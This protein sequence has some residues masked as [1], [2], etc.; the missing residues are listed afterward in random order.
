METSFRK[1]E[2]STTIIGPYF[3]MMVQSIPL[4][5]IGKPR[6]VKDHKAE[7]IAE[8][9]LPLLNV[10]RPMVNQDKNPYEPQQVQLWISSA[11]EKNTFAYDKTIEML[12]L[13]I[14]NPDSAV[15]W[16]FD[17][18]VPI[19]AGLLSQDFLN[20]MKMASTFSE[21]GFAKEYMSRFVG[22]SNEAWFDYEKLL[23]RRRLVNPERRASIPKGSKAYYV[24]SVDVAR[25]GCQTVATILK[26]FPT[27]DKYKANLVNLYVLGKTENEKIFDYQVVELKRLIKQ[28]T[29]KEV[30]IDINGIGVN[31][32]DLMIRP[33]TDPTTGEVYPAYGFSNREEYFRIQPKNCEKILYGIKANAQINSD[34]HS[35]L[36]SM[37]YSGALS[38]LIS[39]K[40]ANTKLM[41]T[42]MGPHMRPEQKNER[43]LPH[44]LTSILLNEIMNLRLKPTG[45][46]TKLAV[47]QINKRIT[48]DKFS[49]LEMG[50]YKIFL[51]EQEALSRKK[52]RGLGRR[53]TFYRTGGG[54]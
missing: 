40:Q 14:I 39:E 2:P 17:Y 50:T 37:V 33:T 25:L 18:R 13:A 23:R 32:A 41:A 36:Y 20:E 34:M 28:F 52:N 35:A 16:G 44:E 9:I 42:K 38:F 54:G 5:N 8:I 48:K 26:V 10:D 51:S 15:I 19:K 6:V 4:T 12:E 21:S 7:D 29:P 53:L 46:E 3:Y 24:I 31:F 30:V 27:E 49:A 1:E 47:E 11:S 22:S 43:L 45:V